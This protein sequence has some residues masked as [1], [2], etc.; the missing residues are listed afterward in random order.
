MDKEVAVF[1]FRVWPI[2]ISDL[3]RNP[4]LRGIGVDA[5]LCRWEVVDAVPAD[6]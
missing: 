1:H 2:L 3:Y 6:L 4:M 5:L